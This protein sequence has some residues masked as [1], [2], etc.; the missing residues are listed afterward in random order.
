M[1]KEKWIP[2]NGTIKGKNHEGYE[3]VPAD[4]LDSVLFLI[5]TDVRIIKEANKEQIY[6]RV[7]GTIKQIL[8][9]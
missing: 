3:L 8:N 9:G 1:D 2:F 6:V 4:K 7:G 5:E